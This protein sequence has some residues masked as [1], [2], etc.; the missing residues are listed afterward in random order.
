MNTCH[1]SHISA[2]SIRTPVFELGEDLTGFIK[3]NIPKNIFKKEM[4][5]AITSKIVSL[6]ERAIAWKHEYPSKMDL[7]RDESDRFL[8]DCRYGTALTIKHNILIPAAGIDESNAQ[9]N[10]YI[11]FPRNPYSSVQR[12]YAELK[13][14]YGLSKFGIILTDSHT[15]PLRRGVTGIGL[16]HWGFVATR[17]LIGKPDLFDRPLTMTYVNVIDAL[18]V[19]AVYAMGESSECTPLAL[20]EATGVAFS[21]E[22]S[23]SEIQIS[24]EDDIYA[25][26]FP[27]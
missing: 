16:A 13:A 7:V 24:S 10:Y 12:L 14:H 4:I 1:G 2:V 27:D 11:L 22:S 9:G 25:P 15:H 21:E 3:K 19:A 23:A 26:L 5:L 17:N 6:S 20:I 18:S 8:A